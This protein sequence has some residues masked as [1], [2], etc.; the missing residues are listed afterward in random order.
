MDLLNIFAFSFGIYFLIALIIVHL[1]K[2]EFSF[3]KDPL[4][5]YANGKWGILIT[6]GL[7]VVGINQIILASNFLKLNYFI[8][9]LFLTLAG[10]GAM[11]AGIIKISETNTPAAH[12]LGALMQFLFFP[13]ALISYSIFANEHLFTLSIGLITLFLLPIICMN[14]LKKKK[15][16]NYG[17][18]QKI[19][20]LLINSWIIII[21]Y[22]RLSS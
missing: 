14:H 15:S 12:K 4:S 22:S 11:I 8:P 16:A 21:P 5:K 19:N 17:L 10:L 20:I 3:K 7:L 6:I 13:L 2:K 1:L 9:F 18:I